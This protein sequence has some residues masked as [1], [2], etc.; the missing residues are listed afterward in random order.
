MRRAN[1]VYLGVRKQCLDE[2]Q[3]DSLA[4]EG[5]L[6][7]KWERIWVIRWPRVLRELRSKISVLEIE[8]VKEPETI[9]TTR[10]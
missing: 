10:Y 9:D 4:L 6:G 2:R 7:Q 1:A 5:P 8:R 3:P